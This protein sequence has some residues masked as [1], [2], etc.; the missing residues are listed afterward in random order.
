M[1]SIF[2]IFEFDA[3]RQRI[4]KFTKTV[5]G[6]EM[7]QKLSLFKDEASLRAAL[8]LVEE[9]FDYL[10][11][12]GELPLNNS[13]DLSIAFHSANI[14]NI[15][16]PSDFDH[17]NSDIKTS[18]KITNIAMSRINKDSRL[19][20]LINGFIDLSPLSERIEQV[21]SPNLSIKDSASSE[22]R[23]IRREIL[24]LETKISRTSGELL[25][26]YKSVISESII[27][28]RNGHY[29]IPIKASEKYNVTGIIHDISQTGQTVYIEPSQIVELNNRLINAKNEELTEINRI[30]RVLTQE[31]LAKE[32]AILSNNELIGHL[33]FLFAKALFGRSTNSYVALISD[34]QEIYLPQARHPLIDEQV[35]V[36]NTF[37]I[38]QENRIVVITGPNAGGKTVALKT[39]GL[40][41]MMNQSGLMLP[42][43]GRARLGYFK[44][45]FA[46]IGDQQS[47]LDNLSTFSA[48]IANIRDI[49]S[50]VKRN[51][52]VLIDELG[53]GTDP[54]EGEALAL[55]LLD[56]LK[57]KGAIAIISSHFSK[58]KTYA[59]ST[60]GVSNASMLFDE[61]ALRPLYIFKLGLPGKSYGLSV[62]T[63]HGLA[64][65]IIKSAESYMAGAGNLKIEEMLARLNEEVEKQEQQ[66]DKLK[67]KEKDLE[68]L[69]KQN[70]QLR[71][72][73]NAKMEKFDQA[74]KEEIE[75]RKIAA[76]KQLDLILKKAYQ[77]DLKPHE[78]IDLK[79]GLNKEDIKVNN[80]DDKTEPLQVGDYVHVETLGSDAKVIK[81]DGKRIVVQL[82]SGLYVKAKR[83]GLSKI[84]APTLEKPKQKAV[85][86]TNLID[87]SPLKMELNLIGLRVE[88]ALAEVARYL[89]R[90]LTK[91]F[92]SVRIIHGFGSGALRKA[93]HEYLKS[94]KYVKDFHLAGP[95]DGAGGA[96]IVEL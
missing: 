57:E 49:T 59:F 14:G 95:H 27:T 63:K 54:V 76:E 74:Y 67:A 56:F 47:L 7:V 77:G 69:V 36:A 42:T 34:E 86:E 24:N 16:T 19:G 2:D 96:T 32:Q 72:R 53:T 31:M 30:L 15:L 65:Q 17:I 68:R 44:S 51:D 70:D 45:I 46:D 43:D 22:L 85:V 89:D 58:L 93:I 79:A 1:K 55:A 88:E 75:E 10:F 12:H 73:L 8:A 81:I 90:C 52:L 23:K 28:M 13:S 66:N 94:Q 87:D 39:I 18:I 91:R 40:L 35:V 80:K 50:R 26:T 83:D 71:A 20:Q 41:V 78:I 84:L 38:S 82:T 61:K 9:V 11:R 62:A 60:A 64:E 4:L 5:R 25:T 29:V 33:D 92:T 6:R 21:V 37:T 48:H 3:I